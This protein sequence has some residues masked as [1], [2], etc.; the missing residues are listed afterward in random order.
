MELSGYQVVLRDIQAEDLELIRAW[1]NDPEV[2]RFML[3]QER[4]SAEQQQAWFSKILK[5]NTQRH[6][7]ICYKDKPIG[8]AN[9]KTVHKGDS[10]E[11]AK[12]LEPGLYIADNRYRG[13]ILAF[14]P[15]L[16]INDYCFERLGTELLQA[17]VKADNTAALKYNAKLGYKQLAKDD[18]IELCLDYQSY[19]VASE[20]IKALLG[21]TKRS[22]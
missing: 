13:N 9:I 18:L 2:S 4:I 5:D 10:I 3:S 21:R 14:S 7:L 6:W 8:V 22:N 17:R 15:T 20:S 1:R 19:R 12:V 16:L 11:T